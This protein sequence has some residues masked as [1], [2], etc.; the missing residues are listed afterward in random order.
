ME[1]K[2]AFGRIT[3]ICITASGWGLFG[4]RTV[5]DLIGYSTIPDDIAVAKTRADQVLDFI[6]TI[7]W[8]ATLGF[9]L[10]ST[11]VLMWV[12]WPRPGD[13]AGPK[14]ATQERPTQVVLHMPEIYEGAHEQLMLFVCNRLLPACGYLLSLQERA[15]RTQCTNGLISNFA[16]EGA[17]TS[18]FRAHYFPLLLISGSPPVFIPFEKMKDHVHFLELNYDGIPTQISFI[19]RE[20][21][22]PVDEFLR[23]HADL[24]NAWQESHGSLVADYD[25]IKQNSKM[26]RLFRPAQPSRWGRAVIQELAACGNFGIQSKAE[27]QVSGAAQ[28]SFII[29]MQRICLFSSSHFTQRAKKPT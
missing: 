20:G 26:G 22:I 27:P 11:V 25:A 19:L 24:Y 4:V 12:S 6:L 10:V 3:S 5:L 21:K 18:P 16:V 8:W 14:R 13:D 1:S 2:R 7:P 28:G 15:I 9:A 17:I 29:T 23:A